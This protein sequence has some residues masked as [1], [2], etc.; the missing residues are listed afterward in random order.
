M[1]QVKTAPIRTVL[2]WIIGTLGMLIIG[3]TTQLVGLFDPTQDKAHNCSCSWSKLII[4]LTGVKVVVNGLEHL[5]RNNPQVLVA[6]HQGSFDIWALSSQLPI[7]FRW[8]VK[9][10]LFKI[11]AL[12]G[13]MRAA[14]DISL[15]RSNPR[16]AMKDIKL[17]LERLKQGRSLIVFPEGTRTRDGKVGEF[18]AGALL[19]AFQSRVPIVPVSIKGSFDI[20]PKNSIWLHPQTIWITIHPPVS[21]KSLSRQDKK[22]IPERLRQI[23]ADDL[24]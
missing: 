10:E 20:M 6:N 7:Q 9:K 3:W 2:A 16:Q 1:E 18:K 22:A 24:K 23:I 14:G 15:D 17:G 5:D 12:G 4:W 21:V 11:P 8:V 19:L 13:A